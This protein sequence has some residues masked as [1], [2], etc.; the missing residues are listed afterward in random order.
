MGS[1]IN[2]LNTINNKVN[3]VFNLLD[4]LYTGLHGWIHVK[5]PWNPQ[6]LQQYSTFDCNSYNN[7]L[8]D[9]SEDCLRD[10]IN[11]CKI[12]TENVNNITDYLNCNSILNYI[13]IYL[14]NEIAIIRNNASHIFTYYQRQ[15]PGEPEYNFLQK[16]YR[17]KEYND[18]FNSL[19]CDSA[20][21]IYAPPIF[22]CNNII[23]CEFGECINIV[24]T[25]KQTINGETKIS[26]ATNCSVETCPTNEQK[27]VAGTPGAGIFN[28]ICQKNKW[29]RL[30]PSPTP[31]A[32]PV[33]PASPA[34]PTAP[35]PTAFTPPTAPAPTPTPTAPAPAPTPTPAPAPTP[36]PTAPA[37][38]PTP[39]ST[40]RSIPISVPTV[41]TLPPKTAPKTTTNYTMFIIVFVVLI[42]LCAFSFFVVS[43]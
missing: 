37:P 9:T 7:N 36:T 38:A 28:W 18:Y 3:E 1:T 42:L 34:P 2:N 24:Q 8:R 40:T 41:R 16:Y 29:V 33:P 6:L 5:T 11:N 17:L 22:C 12:K 4:N 13:R 27:C 21:A 23:N 20:D 19:N 32:P 15:T 39:T 31:P 35:T 43:K 26:N 10:L 30:P 14:R 25:C